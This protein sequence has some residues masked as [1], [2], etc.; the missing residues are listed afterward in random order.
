MGSID[1]LDPGKLLQLGLFFE[2]GKQVL[3]QS[4]KSAGLCAK[5]FA[6]QFV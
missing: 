5:V 6:E 1:W 3:Y 4:G 2:S